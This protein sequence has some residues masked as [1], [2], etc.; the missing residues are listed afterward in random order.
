MMML[1]TATTTMMMVMKLQTNTPS[2]FIIRNS[3][4]LLRLV[5]GGQQVRPP[6]YRQN[7]IS[8]KMNVRPARPTDGR[9]ASAVVMG[10]IF[11][12]VALSI[13]SKTRAGAAAAASVA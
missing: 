10:K 4:P 5:V 7:L 13:T 8:I 3:R 6:M 1:A 9:T 2:P 12:V 11:I